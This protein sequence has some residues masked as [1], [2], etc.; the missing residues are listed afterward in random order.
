[1]L[2]RVQKMMSNA[3][4]THHIIQLVII[5]AELKQ[6]ELPIMYCSKYVLLL[7]G[8]ALLIIPATLK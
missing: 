5:S 1:M 3:T 7:Q 2:E 4:K 6:L 8:V